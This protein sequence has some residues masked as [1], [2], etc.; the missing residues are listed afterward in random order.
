[1]TQPG[2]PIPPSPPGTRPPAPEVAYPAHAD[3]V[4]VGA[5]I[6]GGAC[7]HALAR[8]GGLRVLALERHHK[9]AG[10]TARSAAGFRHQFGSVSNIQMSLLSGRIYGEFARRFGCDEV[11]ERNGY[12]FL[13]SDAAQAE[14]AAARVRL[15]RE[16]GVPD[17]E[18][19]TRAQLAARFP[20]LRCDGLLCG[21]WCPSDGFLRPDAITA[22][23]FEDGK[24]AGGQLFQYS[25]VTRILAS[26]GRV[27]GVE[28]AGKTVIETP[29]VINAAGPWSN[30]VARL[31]GVEIPVVPTKR[32][33]YITNQFKGR[34]V[35]SWPL[36]VFDLEAYCRPETEALMMGWDRLPAMAEGWQRFPPPPFDHDSTS[37]A[38]EPGFG[39]GP[40]DY[41]YEVLARIAERLP[42]LETEAGVEYVTCGYYEVTPDEKAIISWDPRLSGLLHVTGF[43]GHGV[44]HAP[45]AGEAVR[46]LVLG[47]TPPFNLAPFQIDKL[48]RNE[49]R[50][51]PETVVI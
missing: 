1:M 19:L 49:P 26:A 37:D 17:V 39:T 11:F 31:A 28:I 32:Y 2:S 16:Q 47:R 5:G 35:R 22:A 9:M 18:L 13:F 7:F 41:G 43:S 29:V 40:E 20:A 51:D 44:M 23:Y 21:A 15:Q 46:D 3:V 6:V 33:L 24:A 4:I 14:Q 45:A 27:R 50:E 12:L 25:P 48:L 30:K 10:S 38:I 42:F 34:G 36:T 8:A